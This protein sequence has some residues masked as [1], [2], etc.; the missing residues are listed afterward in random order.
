MSESGFDPGLDDPRRAGVFFVTGED[1]DAL[2]AAARDAGLVVRRI[3]LSGCD[4]K[5]ALLLRLAT[6]LDFPGT[7]GRNWDALSDSLRDLSWLP[8]AGHVLLFEQAR[9]LRD[10]DEAGFDTL[11]DIL[12]EASRFWAG[13]DRPF[14]AFLA[15]PEDEFDGMA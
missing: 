2:A 10:H 14:W 1:L 9:A 6:V 11:L 5:A 13:Q 15:L 3:D 12:D 7:A 8:G 4:G